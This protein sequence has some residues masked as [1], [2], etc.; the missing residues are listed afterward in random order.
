MMRL[1]KSA[2]LVA[3]LVAVAGCTVNASAP[4][5][6]RDAPLGAAGAAQPERTQPFTIRRV[7]VRVPT[8]LRVSEANTYYPNADIVWRGDAPGNRWEQVEAIFEEAIGR[9]R[10]KLKQG[11]PVDVQVE[12]LRF[13]SLTEKTRYTIGGVHSIKFK[14]ILLDPETGEVVDARIETA[15]L[16]AYGGSKAIAMEA[17]GLG[18]KV[19]ITQHLAN[20]FAAELSA[21]AVEG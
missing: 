14:L 1:M 6:T 16:K 8:T 17:Q 2:A 15:D 3:T 4:L 10:S 11:R 18:Q 21:R 13:H 12:V 5:A 20:T 7:D 19:R 9:S